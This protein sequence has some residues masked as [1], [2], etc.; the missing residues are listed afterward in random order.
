MDLITVELHCH[1]C[2]SSDSLML[3]SRLLEVCKQRGID[4]IAITDHNEFDGAVKSAE[5]DPDRVIRGEEIMTTQGELLAYY[6]E[7]WIPPN[8]SPEETIDRLRDQGAVISV[9]HPYDSIRGGSW[10]EGD[11]DQILPLIDAIEVFNAR[12]ISSSPDKKAE[13]V[14]SA[15]GMLRTAG[16]DA[17]AYFE[18]GRTVMRLPN[19]NDAESFRLALASAEIIMRR[20][21]PL[22]HLFSRYATFRK[23]LGWKPEGFSPSRSK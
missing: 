17:H 21:S 12:T 20:S 15:K 2:Y 22:V 10:R 13:N 5:I 1:T 19:F 14:A 23:A 8:L 6:V 18:V 3:P 9:A 7:E 16:S 4:R 11:L